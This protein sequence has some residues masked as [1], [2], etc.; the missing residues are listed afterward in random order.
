MSKLKIFNQSKHELQPYAKH[1]DSGFDLPADLPKEGIHLLPFERKL[2][3]TGIFVEVEYGYELQVRP[4]SGNSL[5]KQ[6]DV[7]FGTVDSNYRGEVGVIVQNLSPT[8]CHIND[9]ELI[10][11]AVIAKVEYPDV[12]NVDNLDELTSSERGEKGFGST[13]STVEDRKATE[14]KP[15]STRKKATPKVEEDEAN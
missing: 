3:P 12:E 8:H 7:K 11:Q 5:K 10:A 6:F 14:D 13:G 15:K 4:K 9:G 2:I 1:G